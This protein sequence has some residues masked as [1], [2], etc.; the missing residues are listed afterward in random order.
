MTDHFSIVER[1]ALDLVRDHIENKATYF[2]VPTKQITASDD[3]ILGEGFTYFLISFPSTF[4]VVPMGTGVLEVAWMI[5]LELFVRFSTH[6]ET[7]AKFKAFRS[8]LFN[9]FN[10]TPKGRTL[11]RTAGVRDTLLA[12]AGEPIFYGEEDTPS[13]PVFF[14]QRLE[15][16]VFYKI[17]RT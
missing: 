3:S 4:P 16:S 17:N 6:K 5:P 13:D 14:S 1:A 10:T 12:S 11:N 15:L 2:T 7:W 8:D 9:L